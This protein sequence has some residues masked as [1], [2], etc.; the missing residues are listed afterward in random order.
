MEA[1]RWVAWLGLPLVIHWSHLAKR[2]AHNHH[3]V[4]VIF[5]LAPTN[6]ILGLS[7]EAR[8]TVMLPEA[9]S[10]PRR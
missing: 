2:Q 6:A 1:C 3:A 7:I 8:Q 10:K 4:L 5:G 9:V